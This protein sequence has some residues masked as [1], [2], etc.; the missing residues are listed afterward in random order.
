M[1]AAVNASKS[2][3]VFPAGIFTGV[4]TYPGIVSWSENWRVVHALH[5]NPVPYPAE[6]WRR[7]IPFEL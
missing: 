7:P 5:F 4:N 3:A 2:R 1:V 6:S